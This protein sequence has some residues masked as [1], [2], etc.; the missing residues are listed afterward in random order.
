MLKMT[1]SGSD[2]RTIHLEGKLAGPWI[3]QLRS[4]CEPTIANGVRLVLDCSGLTFV[5]PAGARLLQSLRISGVVLTNR[6]PFL[7]LQIA[8]AVAVEFEIKH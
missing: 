2:T 5:D 8:E 3:E 7:E 1:Q 4:L 6:S